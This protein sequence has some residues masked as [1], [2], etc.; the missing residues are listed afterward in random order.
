MNHILSLFQFVN[1]PSLSMPW[2][3]RFGVI[4]GRQSAPLKSCAAIL[5]F[6]KPAATLMRSIFDEG[7][8]LVERCFVHL[9]NASDP[10][11]GLDLSQE[12]EEAAFRFAEKCSH[13][14]GACL[15]DGRL[16]I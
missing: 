7:L 5:Y 2:P 8:D 3:G 14:A 4:V 6:I 11:K 15:K 1:D 13:V 12:E 9:Q 16:F 10:K